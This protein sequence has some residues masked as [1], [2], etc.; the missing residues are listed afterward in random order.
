MRYFRL[1]PLFALFLPLLFSCNKDLNVNAS[2]KD[3]TVVYGLLDQ[4]Q[5]TNYIKVTKAFLGEGNALEFAKIPDS[6]NYLHGL[7]VKLEEWNQGNYLNTY[8]CD[9]IRIQ[10]KN[11]YDDSISFFYYPNQLL[12]YTTKKLNEN[13]TYILVVTNKQTGKVISGQTGLMHDFDVTRPN[14]TVSFIPN[15]NFEVRWTQAKNGKRYQLVIRFFYMESLKSSPSIKQMKYIDWQVFNNVKPIDA[16]STLPFSLF[17]PGNAFYAVVGAK[18][19]VDPLVD[20]V[21]H[22]CE[23]IFTVAAAELDT[24]MEV[25]EPSLSLVQ[26]RPSYTNITNGIG[27]FSARFMKSVDSLSISQITKD[28]LKI[29]AHTKNL[30]F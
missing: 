21:A 17:F 27:L 19:P 18:I 8:Q 4:T 6:S 23:Y 29:N 11:P 9:S 12:Y 28:S 20:R 22:H 3:I 14:G 16:N 2:W 5:D 7:D 10:N 15:Y 30:G 24:Y 26:E 13:F 1:L 25:T